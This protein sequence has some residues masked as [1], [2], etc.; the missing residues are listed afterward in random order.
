MRKLLSG[1][2][3]CDYRKSNFIW[4]IDPMVIA[5]ALLSATGG[6]A[7]SAVDNQQDHACIRVS[8][9]SAD[10]SDLLRFAV[11]NCN[12]GECTMPLMQAM[13]FFRNYQEAVTYM[14]FVQGGWVSLLTMEQF[15]RYMVISSDLNAYLYGME[16][17]NHPGPMI[18]SIHEFVILLDEVSHDLECNS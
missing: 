17:L 12:D 3:L 11:N 16:T 8:I 15:R 1:L 13:N 4:S 2:L 7:A 14:N 5:L 9:M 18:Q 10:W 6:T